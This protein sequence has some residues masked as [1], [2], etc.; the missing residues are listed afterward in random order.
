MKTRSRGTRSRQSEQGFSLLE[1]LFAALVFTIGMVGVLA[2][3]TMAVNTSRQSDEEL[4][5]KQKAREAMEGIYGARNS[6]SLGYAQINNVGTNDLSTGVSVP[7]IFTVGFTSLYAAGP[8]GVVNTADDAGAGIEYITLNNGTT[9]VL[10]DFQREV[11]VSPFVASD[12][13]VAGNLKQIQ[14]N[15]RYPIA[16]NATRTYTMN[17]LISQY[18]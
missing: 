7:G 8:D 11:R 2:L 15:I 3:F 18:K 17:A 9:R 6:S 14:I 12:G 10:S 13:T 4:I 16:R 1:V 5:A